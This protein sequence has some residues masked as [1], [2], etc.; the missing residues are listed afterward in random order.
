MSKT[1]TPKDD[2]NK[3]IQ[4][5]IQKQYEDVFPEENT[6]PS[7]LNMRQVEA[8]KARVIE[9]EA[10]LAQGDPDAS[11]ELHTTSKV[12]P[13][14]SLGTPGKNDSREQGEQRILLPKRPFSLRSKLTLAITITTLLAVT[15]LGYF[16]YLRT[17]QIQNIL[18][19]QLET[20]VE[21]SIET[22]LRDI[23]SIELMNADSFLQKVAE[24][25]N[26]S[27]A[28]ASQLLEQKEILS[29][30]EYWNAGERLFSLASGQMD[31]SDSDPAAVF[32]PKDVPLTDDLQSQLNTLIQLDFIGPSTLVANP[33]LVALYYI[34][35]QGVTIYYPNIDLAHLVPTDFNPSSEV[36]YQIGTPQNNPERKNA[37]T[38]PYQDPARTG[39]IVTNVS[40]I[41]DRSGNFHGVLGADVQLDKITGHISTIQIGKTGYAFLID[42]EGHIIAMPARGYEDFGFTQEVVPVGESPKQSVLDVDSLEVQAVF[43]Q[44]TEGKNDLSR[45]NLHG[46]EHYL[47]YGP[48]PTT[49]Y[50][51]GLIV[52]VAEMN[53][54]V[55]QA[56]SR[57]G[58]QASTSLRYGIFLFGAIL[59]SAVFVSTG[60]SRIITTPLEKLTQAVQGISTGDLNQKITVTSRDEVGLLGITFNNMAAQLRDLFESL[61]RRVTERTHDLE[62]ASEV[63]RTVSQKVENLSEMLAEAVEMIRARFNLYYTQIYLTDPSG[64]TMI[65][66]AGTGEVGKEL[67]QKGHFLSIDSGSLNGRAALEKRAVI[68]TDTQG[69]PS[70]LPNPL[71]PKTC[72]EMSIPLIAAGNVVGVLDMQSEQPGALNETNLPAFETLAGQLAIAVQNAALLAQAEEARTQVEAQIHRLTEQGWRD[73]LDAIEHGQKIGYAFEQGKIVHLQTDA[74][75]SGAKD[76]ELCIPIALTGTKIGEIHL[77]TENDHTWTPNEL[78]LIKV[79]SAQLAQ[80]IE[81][82]RLLAQAESYRAEA[83]KAVQRLTHEGWNIFMQSHN[84][85]ESGYLFD[86][87]EVKPLE[88]RGNGHFNYAVKQPMVVGDQ[89]I[90]ELAVDTP[91]QSDEAAEVIAAVAKQLSG[92]IE[93]LRLSELNEQH[94]QRE[95]TLRKITSALRSSNNPAT[96]MRT[97]V[98]ELG[99]VMG[100]RAIVQLAS[101]QRAEQAESAVSPE[102][103]SSAPARPS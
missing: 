29:K 11:A 75:L 43:K 50:S 37:W 67:R 89:V 18:G 14:F 48:L 3:F 81:N 78:E 98:R 6:P 22:N 93:N 90:G 62:L 92:H 74:L 28:Y 9:L 95:Q 21:T 97:A 10:K 42:P 99:S 85:L 38:A 54:P 88:A 24:D 26:I 102:N 71:L 47:V 69:N 19:G 56:Q 103:G 72:S 83:E 36:F 66:H 59:L 39:L 2:E 15:A 40:P 45:I 20:S 5:K 31:N 41:Y 13:W 70:F 1:R 96:I 17:T 27:A 4:E 100:R 33:N 49:G 16:A 32:V 76:E 57:I 86:L 30:G 51:I 12:G 73:F 101:P 53:E 7:H 64:K 35:P 60:L 58:E 55:I 79:T 25:I 94:A 46:V 68:V 61:E 87:T 8:L 63:G 84:E 91:E 65:L 77:P 34:N 23:L 82:L 80:H 44:M 52:P